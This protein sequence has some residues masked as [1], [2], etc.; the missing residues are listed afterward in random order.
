M[1]GNL[2]SYW[3]MHLERMDSFFSNPNPL[4][5]GVSN[6]RPVDHIQPRRAMNVILHKIVNLLKTLFLLT[7]FH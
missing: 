3:L 7:S 1:D 6:L 2:N 5:S 4:E